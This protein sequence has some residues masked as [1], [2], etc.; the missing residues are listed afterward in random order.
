MLT[1]ERWETEGEISRQERRLHRAF[2]KLARS[3][4]KEPNGRWLNRNVDLLVA[5]KT[6]YSYVLAA[7]EGE[8]TEVEPED[9]LLRRVWKFNGFL[10]ETGLFEYAIAGGLDEDFR[11][12]I[13]RTTAITTFLAN[14][15]S[16][17]RSGRLKAGKETYGKVRR[18]LRRYF[19]KL[20]DLWWDV[21]ALREA[22]RRREEGD[23]PAEETERFL[24]ALLEKHGG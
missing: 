21:Y 3:F 18:L 11:D 24:N 22:E 6:A 10:K 23:E 5:L 17:V 8:G 9:D 12:E 4:L 20:E 2:L 14:V 16:A 7:P 15:V 19:E 13:E 1:L